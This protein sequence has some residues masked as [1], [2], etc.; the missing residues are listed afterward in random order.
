MEAATGAVRAQAYRA[1]VRRRTVFPRPA[2]RFGKVAGMSVSHSHQT[3]TLARGKHTSPR[4]GACVMELASMLAGEEFTDR[5]AS[6]C[7]VVAAFLRAYNDAVDDRRRQD[8][9]RYASAAVG[10]RTSSDV[11]RA[12]ALRC[13]EELR[14]LRRWPFALTAPRAMP[15]S[16]PGI[17]RLAGRLAREMHRSGIG[18]HARALAFADDLLAIGPATTPETLVPAGLSGSGPSPAVARAR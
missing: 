2:P 1:V 16:V 15:D 17:E 12:R 5:P 13:L 10:S 18:S 3:V 9:Y 7:P 11:M 14:A 6:V 8:L 4:S